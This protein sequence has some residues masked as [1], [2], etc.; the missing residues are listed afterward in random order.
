MQK[1][2]INKLG[3]IDHAELECTKWM[4]FIGAQST[5]KSTVAKAI[6]F[7]RMII[8]ESIFD[9]AAT[10]LDTVNP[11]YKKPFISSITSTI[12]ERFIDVFGLPDALDKNM[13]LEFYYDNQ[14]YIKIT[15]STGKFINIEFSV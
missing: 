11:A 14:T 13:S 1:I 4:V 12:H 15:L 5:G 10:R 9:L 8:K 2:I 7:F 6:F 3:P